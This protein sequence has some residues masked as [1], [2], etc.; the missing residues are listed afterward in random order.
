MKL[1]LSLFEQ[2]SGLKINFYKSEIFS[3]GKA[4]EMQ[5]DYRQIFGCEVGALPFK[6]LGIPIRYRKL[7]NKEWKPA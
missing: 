1:I 2:F 3:F 4:K 6:Y 7:I 5:N